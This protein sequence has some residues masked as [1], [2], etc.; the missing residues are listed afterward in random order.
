M[1]TL[2][3]LFAAA[4]LAGCSLSELRDRVSDPGSAGKDLVSGSK[5]GKLLLE[6]DHPS[7]AAPH[8]AALDGLKATLRGVTG[9]TSVDVSLDA[10][11]PSEPSKKY[12]YEQLQAL[13]RE[14][15]DRHSGG[16]TAVLYVLYVA[17]G[18]ADDG[19][20]GVTLGAA[21]GGT[22]LVMFKG[23]IRDNSGS[24]PLS[25]RP[26]EQALEQAVLTHEFGHAAGL[27]NLGTPMV[28][29][30]E[31]PEHRGHS[32]N[33]ESVMYWAV[34]NTAGLLGLLQCGLGS[35]DCGIPMAFDADDKADL[36]A[37]REG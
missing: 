22:S 18:S 4:L 28:R 31:D 17:G 36:T 21:Y 6:I 25:G 30:H 15:R 7:G 24:G 27:V 16:D 3:A 12:S 34:E 37:L 8:A 23:N 14:H 26:T 35:G 33:R 29:P 2:L 19:D 32:S 20:A 9:K 13:E 1:R 5:Y 10:S 11:I